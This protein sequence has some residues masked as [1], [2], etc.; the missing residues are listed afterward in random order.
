MLPPEIQNI[1]S[2]ALPTRVIFSNLAGRKAMVTEQLWKYLPPSE[3]AWS[4]C[5]IYFDYAAWL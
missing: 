5:E 3:K 1:A 4:L 2:T